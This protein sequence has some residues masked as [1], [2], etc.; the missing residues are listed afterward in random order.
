LRFL[1]LPCRRRG[2]RNIS[3]IS[4]TATAIVTAA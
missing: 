4:V 2:L 1:Y 3:Y